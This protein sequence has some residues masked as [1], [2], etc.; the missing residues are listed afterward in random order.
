MTVQ[1]YVNYQM[2]QLCSQRI[3]QLLGT[4]RSQQQ[5]LLSSVTIQQFL[6]PHTQFSQPQF[7]L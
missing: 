4:L 3:G 5:L 7:S 6:R 1:F 2:Q